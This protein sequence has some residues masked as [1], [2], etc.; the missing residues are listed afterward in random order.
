MA[1][2]VKSSQDVLETEFGEFI[3]LLR[4]ELPMWSL[5]EVHKR[6]PSCAGSTFQTPPTTTGRARSSRAELGSAGAEYVCEES[7]QGRGKELA[8]KQG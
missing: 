5:T 2:C 8:R 4:R 3:A 6:R 1:P 7:R